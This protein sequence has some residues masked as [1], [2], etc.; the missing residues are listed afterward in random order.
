VV[1]G[2]DALA[3][4]NILTRRANQ[5]HY[6]IIAQFVRLP[7]ALPLALPIGLPARLQAKNPDS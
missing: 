4:E 6:S 2:V 5:P 7:I 1:A 3:C